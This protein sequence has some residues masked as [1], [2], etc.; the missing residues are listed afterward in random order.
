MNSIGLAQMLRHW[1]LENHPYVRMSSGA[2]GHLEY[3]VATKVWWLLLV[4]YEIPIPSTSKFDEVRISREY[5]PE[6]VRRL[7]NPELAE[8]YKVLWNNLAII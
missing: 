7:V 3:R 2:P 8:I 6:W 5:Q 4:P 1:Q